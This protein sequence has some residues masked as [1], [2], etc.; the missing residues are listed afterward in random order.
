MG[1]FDNDWECSECG[2]LQSKHN[3]FYDGKCET[4]N[5]KLKDEVEDI[6]ISHW[7]R[8]IGQEPDNYEDI[9]QGVYEIILGDERTMVEVADVMDALKTYNLKIKKEG[10]EFFLGSIFN[11]ICIDRPDNF[12]SILDFVFDDVNDTADKEN[13]HDGDVA[14]AFRRWIEAQ[15]NN[16]DYSQD[17]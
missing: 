15:N 1:K 12:D 10:V 7:V 11:R 6:L 16:G 9:V 4:C 14:I 5:F 8:T 13:W 2:E 17:H 3:Q